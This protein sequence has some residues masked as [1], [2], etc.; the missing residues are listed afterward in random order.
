MTR[1]S[2]WG[3]GRGA[4]VGAVTALAVGAVASIGAAM[5]PARTPAA[6]SQ[7]P[8]K[9]TICHRT[10]SK[11]N[12]F[13]TIIV[14]RN[15]LPAHLGHGDKIGPCPAP[16]GKKSK[17]PHRKSGTHAN[18]S[19]KHNAPAETSRARS[20]ST[21]SQAPSAPGHSGSAPGRSATS[22]RHIGKFQPDSKVTERQRQHA[23]PQQYTTEPERHRAG[24]RSEHARALRRCSRPSGE[25][26]RKLRKRTRPYRER[27]RTRY[28]PTWTLRQRPWAWRRAP[29]PGKEVGGRSRSGGTFRFLQ[30]PRPTT[31][32][33]LVNRPVRGGRV[34]AY[35]R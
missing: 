17:A 24:P 22:P 25:P 12:P 19:K 9:V 14:S 18:K 2:R 27:A 20:G 1:P 6:A 26:A 32:L 3:W 28:E 10:H 15:A 4:A 30:G 23:G 29:R 7:Y 31:E 5:S 34:G 21:A 11:K 8:K 13:V 35:W 16:K 33:I